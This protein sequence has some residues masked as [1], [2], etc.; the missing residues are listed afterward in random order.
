MHRLNQF[1]WILK[2]T[3]PLANQGTFFRGQSDET[4]KKKYLLKTLQG[5]FLSVRFC[6]CQI[7]VVLIVF[8]WFSTWKMFGYTLRRTRWNCIF[9]VGED[10]GIMHSKKWNESAWSPSSTKNECSTALSAPLFECVITW[11][12][13]WKKCSFT[14][15]T[16]L[17]VGPSLKS[18]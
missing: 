9:Y 2:V 8:I 13:S 5:K 15:S 6:F 12:S 18:L 1:V 14:Q 17:P 4:N 11:S 16:R 7:S 3:K 10:Q